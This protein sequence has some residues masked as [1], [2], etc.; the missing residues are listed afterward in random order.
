MSD[1]DQPGARPDPAPADAG[2][3]ADRES[4]PVHGATPADR[5]ATGSGPTPDSAASAVPAA[6]GPAAVPGAAPRADP[7]TGGAGDRTGDPAGDPAGDRAVAPHRRTPRFLTVVLGLAGLMVVLFFVQ[8]AK[9][10]VAPVF[11]GL[12]LLIVVY[13]LQR[14]LEQHVHRFVA[15]T[16]S[17]VIVVG[18]ILGFFL[19]AGWAVS[20]LVVELPSHNAEFVALWRDA[21]AWLDGLGIST[22][23]IQQGLSGFNAGS[24]MSLLTPVLSNVT[25]VSG[26]VATLILAV[27]FLALDSMSLP[28]RLGL[29]A[30]NRPHITA[31][32]GA[33]AVGVRRYWLVTTVFGL[34]VAVLD[35]V[36]LSVIGVPLVWAWGVLAFLTNYIP[37]IGFVI[38]LV[39]PAL[40]ALLD[41]GWWA[42]LAV[43][44]AYSLL[45]FVIQSII[46]PKFTGQSVGVTPAM[47]F[48]SLMFWYWV[49]G[50]IGALVALPATLLVKAL[51]VDADP[52]A[53]WVNAFI[54]SSPS[55][56]D[57]TRPAD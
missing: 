40:L 27:F 52:R 39:P 1:R 29:V 14:W 47:S 51:L 55:P 6:V 50:W 3:R 22:S 10:V 44:I 25:A 41:G 32:L 26:A 16:V 7:H 30:R 15:A 24:V 36:A 11:L 38:G 4:E 33:F 21:L 31:A 46:Q 45:N 12:N 2:T 5:P 48:L 42:A 13:P 56:S 28:G 9:D 37:N 34:I 57:A 20:E 35:V 43:V 53:R 8:A 19:L 49:L 18:I 23:V 54:S 17:L